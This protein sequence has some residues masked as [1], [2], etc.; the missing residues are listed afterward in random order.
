MMA[1]IESHSLNIWGCVLYIE[2][3]VWGIGIILKGGELS[4]TIQRHCIYQISVLNG[5]EMKQNGFSPIFRDD[6]L[7]DGTWWLLNSIQQNKSMAP[8][9]SFMN[10]EQFHQSQ[11]SFSLCIKKSMQIHF[12]ICIEL[13]DFDLRQR[14]TRFKTRHLYC[15][16]LPFHSAI[17]R[18]ELKECNV[19][20][21]L[22]IASVLLLSHVLLWS[23]DLSCRLAQ[24]TDT[25]STGSCLWYKRSIFCSSMA[26]PWEREMEQW[27][28]TGCCPV[29]N[30]CMKSHG[31]FLAHAML[32][33]IQPCHPAKL[34]TLCT[35]CKCFETVN[36][37][38]LNNCEHFNAYFFKIFQRWFGG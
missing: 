5:N 22:G 23:K 31:T 15:D 26:Y 11:H 8:F 3:Q 14:F 34:V 32:G 2:T 6:S 35:A 25:V 12:C 38:F 24:S 37:M 7:G 13:V 10:G 29:A 9:N 36:D 28:I 19:T 17:S 27:K 33:F 21:S 1:N 4:L 30:L 18:H 16:S 20:N